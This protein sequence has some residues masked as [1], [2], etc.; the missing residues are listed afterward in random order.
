MQSASP[1]GMGK[2]LDRLGWPHVSLK[3]FWRD[4][5]SEVQKHNTTNGAAAL[6]YFLMLSIFPAALALLTLLP[7]LRIPNLDGMI[8]DFLNQSLPGD[9]AKMFTGTIR[10]I[11]NKPQG[12]LL[13]FGLLAALWAASNGTFAVMQQLNITYDV[14]EGRSFIKTRATAMGLTFLC[15][16]LVIIA[17][18][19]IIFGGVIQVWMEQTLGLGD[20]I[21]ALFAVFRWVVIAGAMTMAFAC[22]YYFGPDVQQ[23]FKF[24]SPG[25][26]FGVAL[27]TVAS[28]GFRFYVNNFGKYNATYG[29]IGAV[30]VLMLWLNLMGLVILMGSEI[31]SL[32]EHYSPQG[33]SKG[34]KL[35]PDTRVAA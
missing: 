8:L 27:L 23:K 30:I 22:T 19:L 12:G 7:Y 2:F 20:V 17:F 5:K 29:G 10:E 16:G 1:A 9:A 26:L 32:V 21:R 3:T 24:I 33:K 14:K 11:T 13:S 6:A 25:S 18:G 35:E 28:L 34:E 31:N 4:I 15:G